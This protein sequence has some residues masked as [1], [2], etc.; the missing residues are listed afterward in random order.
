MIVD[1]EELTGTKQAVLLVLMAEARAVRNPELAAL[2]PELKKQDRDEL[3]RRG[4]IEVSTENRAMV[5]E[6][7]DRGWATCA[8]II[9]AEVPAQSKGQ[10]KALY[11][12]LR[13][14]RRY[15]DR[16]GLKPGEVF[17]PLDDNALAGE[18][19]VLGDEVEEKVRAAYVRLAA[20]SGGWVD[21][22]RLRQDLLEVSRHDLDA[23][24]T[25]MY[26]IPGVSLVPEENQKT[27]T[28]EDHAAAVSIG[29][30]AKHLIAIEI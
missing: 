25:R 13:A 15:F 26:R 20:R 3:V 11:T 4:L 6:L 19:D 2:G 8:A 23:A 17:F 5:L 12:V 1:P 16:E 21:L 27:L 7:T 30:Q 24:L 14:L 28:A 18:P 22:V 29:D 10:G 9:G